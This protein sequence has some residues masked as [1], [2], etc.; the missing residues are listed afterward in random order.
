MGKAGE[1]IDQAQND[2][3]RSRPSTR[4][5]NVSNASSGL[6]SVQQSAGNL[7]IE[8][9][10]RPA[11]QA[12]L[13][14][15]RLGDSDEPLQFAP[16]ND[17][18]DTGNLGIQ[19]STLSPLANPEQQ[20]QTPAP[21]VVIHWSE[22][23]PYIFTVDDD[24][25]ASAI[26]IEIY[27]ADIT[28]FQPLE[29]SPFGSFYVANIDLLRPVYRDYV[30]EHLLSQLRADIEVL[31]NL[32]FYNLFGDP[33]MDIVQRWAAR[34]DLRAPGGRTYFDVFLG[35]LRDD[36]WY[37]DYLITTGA[38][39][40]YF[41]SMFD[42]AGDDAVELS[43]LIGKNSREFGA[44][45]PAWAMVER[46]IQPQMAGAQPAQPLQVNSE[47]VTRTTDFILSR[48]KGVTFAG[49]SHEIVDL[50][51]NLP[52][53]EQVAVLNGIESHYDDR[54]LF[55]LVGKYGEASGTGMLYWLFDD[56]KSA[57]RDR[58]AKS[59]VDNGVF[60]NDSAQ[61]LAAGR[62]IISRTLPWITGKISELAEERAEYWADKAVHDDSKMAYVW[63]SLDSLFDRQ[64]IDF[65]IFTLIAPK[66]FKGVGN[67]SPTLGKILGGALL[68]KTGFD[69]SV[70]A[71]DLLLNYHQM[72]G[73]ERL[74]KIL[75]LASTALMIGAG[76]MQNRLPAAKDVPQ[77]PAAEQPKLL[78]SG[79]PAE[80]GT[81]PV[82]SGPGGALAIRPPM[83]PGGTTPSGPQVEWRI[84]NVNEQTGDITAV[85]RQG[86]DYG[87]IRINLETGNGEA[88]H[89]ASGQVIPI[90]GGVLVGPEP[91]LPGSAEPTAPSPGPFALAPGARALP[92]AAPPVPVVP[93]VVRVPGT[94]TPEH[95]QDLGFDP[96]TQRFRQSE[97]DTALRLEAARGVNLER[98]HPANAAQKGDWY[99]PANPTEIYDGC[100]PGASRYFD[101]QIANG[102]YETALREHLAHPTVAFVVIDI[103]DLGLTAAQQAALDALI[104]RVAGAAN[105]KIVRIP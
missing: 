98:F 29:K 101:R 41:D 75:N 54:E 87:F 1:K 61:A 100:S 58:L 103:T 102:N 64:H 44:Y 33:G 49:E 26:S 31:E 84:I 70:T 36:Y 68:I 32:I 55:G 51:I 56:L 3:A 13:N 88:I 40:T 85:G 95:Y 16:P 37:R 28:S 6:S 5:A 57:D 59:L 97:A 86:S 104:I 53:P 76:A 10:L 77:L 34:A 39:H 12:T 27:G 38:K 42:C 92:G 72:S 25:T 18:F 7:S 81:G 21:P 15:S 105:P 96:A 30:Q 65:T 46:V 82:E 90:R 52:A 14:V 78:T 4:S 50:M 71:L 66:L 20:P 47:L 43:I 73:V 67:L 24:P 62:K 94:Y 19:Q 83:L 93:V 60:S 17:L 99:N 11:T 22:S 2:A 63:G 79:N 35:R 45:R 9:L 74:S 80:E 69:A 8:R 23:V 48:L 89:P 91:L